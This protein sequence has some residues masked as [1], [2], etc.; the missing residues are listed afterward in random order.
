MQD[1]GAEVIGNRPQMSLDENRQR[2]KSNGKKSS[3][4]QLPS[5]FRREVDG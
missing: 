1:A 4:F 5:G 3:F 2:S